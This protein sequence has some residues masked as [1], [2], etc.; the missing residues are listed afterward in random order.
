MILIASNR[1]SN[2]EKAKKFLSSKGME[3][4]MVSLNNFKANL[5]DGIGLIIYDVYDLRDR[6]VENVRLAS[7]MGIP[8]ILVTAYPKKKALKEI[9]K[10]WTDGAI[11]GYLLKPV[12]VDN[13]SDAME[14]ALYH[15]IQRDGY[16]YSFKRKQKIL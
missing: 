8:V 13:L 14:K 11:K 12:T 2:M 16:D 6:D 4:S 3:V 10:L 7:Q 9:S 5:R 15:H 1:S